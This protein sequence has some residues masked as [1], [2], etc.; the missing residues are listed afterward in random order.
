[1]E[2]YTGLSSQRHGSIVGPKF[3]SAAK[4]VE[5]SFS[6]SLLPSSRALGL[7]E[8]FSQSC[9][10][11]HWK[12][13][14]Y[15]LHELMCRDPRKTGGQR[16]GQLAAQGTLPSLHLITV[17]DT[18]TLF[19]A[20]QVVLSLSFHRPTSISL[21]QPPLSKATVVPLAWLYQLNNVTLQRQKAMYLLPNQRPEGSYLKITSVCVGISLLRVNVHDHCLLFRKAIPKG[22]QAHSPGDKG[23]RIQ[24]ATRGEGAR[25]HAPSL[26]LESNGFRSHYCGIWSYFL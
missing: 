18:R 4:R 20:Q 12:L 3:R 15:L 26:A 19:N 5:T 21:K 14:A 9:V 8:A 10:L 16:G 17:D 24:V 11:G 7:A 22:L 13:T 1:M 2:L 6:P 25:G 23:K